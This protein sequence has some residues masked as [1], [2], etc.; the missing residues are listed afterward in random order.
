M[1]DSTEGHYG[2]Y[3]CETGII[4]PARSLGSAATTQV[5]ARH[6]ALHAHIRYYLPGMLFTGV[7]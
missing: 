1:P 6:M 2:D 3:H 5:A 7:N 4:L